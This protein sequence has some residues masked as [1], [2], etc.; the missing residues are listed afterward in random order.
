MADEG[1]M[2]WHNA[3]NKTHCLRCSLVGYPYPAATQSCLPSSAL[4]IFRLHLIRAVQFVCYDQ[5]ESEDIEL[6][7]TSD[8]NDSIGI[9]LWQQ[10]KAL[11]INS[12]CS[13]L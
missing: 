6:S 3:M 11:V 7:L 10:L 2:K 1:Y 9:M 4:N 5:G 12:G 8:S 13:L